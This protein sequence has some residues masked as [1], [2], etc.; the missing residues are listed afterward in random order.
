MFGIKTFLQQEREK[1]LGN[2]SK[3]LIIGANGQLAFDLIRILKN[4]HKVFKATHEDFDVIDFEKVEKFISK[5]K[6][7]VV[8]NTA[9]F[10]KT[11]ECE[12][13]PKKSFDINAVGAYNVAKSA[14]KIGAKVF[15]MSTNYV[16]D[17]KKKIYYENDFPR[18]LNVYGA[19]KFAGEILTKIANPRFYIIRSSGLFG[20]HQ[21]GKGHNFVTLMLDKAKKHEEINVVNNEFSSFTY[22]FDLALAIQK[23]I[24]KKSSP[25]GIYH[26]TNSGSGS[27]YDFAKAILKVSKTGVNPI[28][29]NSSQI[30]S[31]I[32]RPVY[33][34]MANKKTTKLRHWKE[35]LKAFI[36]E[37]S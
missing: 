26:I 27:W 13:N 24:H 8:I 4:K 16:F 31:I 28:S 29:I 22:T 32:K 19:S 34:A 36:N 2:M 20:S 18:P 30:P 11:S 7:E 14:D 15:F 1:I 9:A 10:H 17:G 25:P 12:L 3:I 35:A 37:N 6:P 33:S 23:L 5:L 21:S